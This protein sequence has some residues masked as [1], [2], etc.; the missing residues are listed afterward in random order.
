MIS[1]FNCYGFKK[2]MLN[3]NNDDTDIYI[4]IECFLLFI[5][6]KLP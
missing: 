5:S 3:Y 2:K 1:V 6:F 4:K